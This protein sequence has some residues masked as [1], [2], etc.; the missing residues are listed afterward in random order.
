MKTN[1][2]FIVGFNDKITYEKVNDEYCVYNK[3]TN[4]MV[5]L[6]STASVVF[7]FIIN[8]NATE[9]KSNIDDVVAY[10]RKFVE[11]SEHHQTDVYLDIE[12]VLREINKEN[13]VSISFT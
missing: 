3:E 12:N 6:N 2:E 1:K 9:N 11:F 7:E 10:M 4:R 5:I 13:I 8:L